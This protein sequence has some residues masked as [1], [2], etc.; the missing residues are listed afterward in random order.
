M[1]RVTHVRNG[2]VSSPS[3]VIASKLPTP[4]IANAIAIPTSTTSFICPA[5]GF[6]VGSA[7]SQSTSQNI[8]SF[9]VAGRTYTINRNNPEAGGINTAPIPCN[10]NDEVTTSN[11]ASATFYP[12]LPS[13]YTNLTDITP[14]QMVNK[15]GAFTPTAAGTGL[16]LDVMQSGS[17]ISIRIS[18]TKANTSA[19][20]I[21]TIS[22][23]VFKKNVQFT[24]VNGDGNILRIECAPSGQVGL[25]GTPIASWVVGSTSFNNDDEADVQKLAKYNPYIIGAPD[26]ANK[27]TTN[28]GSGTSGTFTAPS[29]G[30]VRSEITFTQANKS[31]YLSIGGENMAKVMS[32]D[33]DLGSVQFSSLVPILKDQVVTFGGTGNQTK[34][35]TFYPERTA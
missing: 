10:M 13:C 27:G 17:I 26:I 15:V 4:D 16:N 14:T 1:K 12:V 31:S 2:Q 34:T 32:F 21:G 22:N 5:D 20:I 3:Q 33:V 35:L 9:T 24:A 18:G 19:G 29:N 23:I 25:Y 11:R 8:A 6:I 28:M 30:W 7:G